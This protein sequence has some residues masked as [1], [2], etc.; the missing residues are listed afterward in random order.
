MESAF[1]EVKGVVSATS[2]YTGGHTADPT[3]EDVS[4]GS[5]GH[6]EAVE[7]VGGGQADRPACACHR[8]SHLS[9]SIIPDVLST[10]ATRVPAAP[11]ILSEAGWVGVER[12]ISKCVT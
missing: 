12:R 8:R 11:V 1:E 7:V 2:G 10:S 5:T 9:K 4:F 3:Y 6:Y